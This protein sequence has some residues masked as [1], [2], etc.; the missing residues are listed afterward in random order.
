MLTGLTRHRVG[1]RGRMILEVQVWRRA[2][3]PGIHPDSQRWHAVWRDANFRDV[4]ELAERTFS[5][6][7]PA[8]SASLGPRS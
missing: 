4:I 5:A 2:H 3:V 7:A 8:R 6:E 1:W